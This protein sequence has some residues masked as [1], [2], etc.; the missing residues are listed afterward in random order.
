MA[1]LVSKSMSSREDVYDISVNEDHCF[2]ANN[3]LVHNCGEIALTVLGGFCVIADVVPFHADSLEE[4]E[5]AFRAATRALIRVNTMNSIYG[6]EV[7]RTNRIGVG[8][9]GIHEFAWKFFG[10]GFRDL[11]DEEKSKHFWMTLARFNRA[12][13]QEA[14]LYCK[15]HNLTVPHT[16]TT[17][18]PAGCM[19]S[20]TVI[21]TDKGNLSL[22]EIFTQNGYD[23]DNY[24]GMSGVWLDLKESISVYDKDNN[25]KPVTQL[26]V[27]GKQQTMRVEFE[28]G[29]SVDVTPNHMFLTKEKGWVR[30]DELDGSE[31]IVNW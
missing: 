15:K 3:I 6:K 26:Y 1:K 9:T 2:Y 11:L 21:R 4:A 24:V 28:D 13:R 5:D 19:D 17:I 25:L 14:E 22:A 8:M 10:L 29:L 20:S 7:A 18:K 12:V 27:N 16:M 23:L 30:A 31:D